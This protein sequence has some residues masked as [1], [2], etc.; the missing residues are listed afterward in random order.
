MITAFCRVDQVNIAGPDMDVLPKKTISNNVAER[1]RKVNGYEDTKD[2]GERAEI[3]RRGT[4]Q[5]RK[6]R[7]DVGRILEEMLEA[8]HDPN[9]E[10]P[11]WDYDGLYM[12]KPELSFMGAIL[13]S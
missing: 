11:A 4:K 3:A 12:E 2:E 10:W 8:R 9:V 1:Y 6:I 13:H 7:D 5:K